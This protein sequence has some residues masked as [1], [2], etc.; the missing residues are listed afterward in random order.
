MTVR[1]QGAGAYVSGVPARDLTDE[2]Y[3]A[4]SDELRERLTAS[5]L[6]EIAPG[7]EPTMA[8]DETPTPELIPE[9]EPEPEPTPEPEPEPPATA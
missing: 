9:P 7:G 8:P 3:A 5:G 2:E 4:L 6:Y 1:Y